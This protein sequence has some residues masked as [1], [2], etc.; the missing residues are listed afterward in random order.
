M[1]VVYLQYW[2]G[3]CHMKLLPSW[4]RF[5]VHCTTMHHVTSCKDACL[6]TCT[7][8]RMTKIFYVLLQYHR[9]GMDTEIRVSTES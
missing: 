8:G 5:W 7:F 2:H 1:E 4:C 9:G 3:W 6:A